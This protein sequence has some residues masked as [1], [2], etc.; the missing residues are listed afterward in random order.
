MKECIQMHPKLD[1]MTIEIMVDD[2]LN[3]PENMQK[4]ME[5]DESFMTNF[6]E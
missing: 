4:E 1:N 5:K 3:N 2:W 6:K